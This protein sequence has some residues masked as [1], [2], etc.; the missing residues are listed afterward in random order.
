LPFDL[1]AAGAPGCHLY[2]D[3]L[4]LGVA[5]TDARPGWPFGDA[6]VDLALPLD[7]NLVGGTVFSQ[8]LLVNSAVNSLGIATSHGVEARLEPVLPA[9]SYAM[10]VSYD[11]AA[12]T[13]KVE[14]HLFP[15]V[16]FEA[17]RQ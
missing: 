5:V 15:V 4:L 7:A 17:T 13:G 10:V 9:T 3:W 8:W 1:A 2:N 14:T 16:R 6:R 11:A 12:P